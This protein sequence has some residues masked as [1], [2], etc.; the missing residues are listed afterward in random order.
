M[1]Q[2]RNKD[3]ANAKQEL[4]SLDEGASRCLYDT[5]AELTAS[6]TLLKTQS[7]GHD[8]EKLCFLLQGVSKA[9]EKFDLQ[10]GIF[11]TLTSSPA[12]ELH[13]ERIRLDRV[14]EDIIAE[15]S[16]QWTGRQVKFKVQPWI[17]AWCDRRLMRQVL[18]E[19]FSNALDLLPHDEPGLIEF[20][21]VYRNE[22]AVY[23]VRDNSKNFSTSQAEILFE[24]FS[25]TFQTADL[26][27]K[28]LK[29][30]RAGQLIRR[31]GGKVW[32]EVISGTSF[33]I[34]FSAYTR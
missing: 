22:Q 31:H 5:A 28:T 24:P 14:A 25:D 21:R 33:T 7:E 23:Y 6:I 18:Q 11:A 27:V 12:G 9:S 17:T 29:L 2:Q 1:L 8:N 32:A 15:L 13:R 10:L 20:G 19:F 16:D 26:S 4:E 3:L 34:Y 30:V